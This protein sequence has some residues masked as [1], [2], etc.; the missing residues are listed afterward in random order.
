MGGQS[1]ST[2]EAAEAAETP[3][4]QITKWDN[5]RLCQSTTV[6]PSGDCRQRMYSIIGFARFVWLKLRR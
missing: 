3:L 2:S 5:Y 6:I 1:C 4:K